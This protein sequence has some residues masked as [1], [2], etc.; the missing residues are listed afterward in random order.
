MR[1]LFFICACLG[2]EVASSTNPDLRMI[3]DLNECVRVRFETTQ[4]VAETVKLASE[5]SVF[6]LN[7]GTVPALQKTTAS[8]RSSQCSKQRIFKLDFS[9][10]G[11]RFWIQIRKSWIFEP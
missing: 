5:P 1:W 3:D 7:P 2:A 11:G 6:G 4:T 9:C 8:K 10:S